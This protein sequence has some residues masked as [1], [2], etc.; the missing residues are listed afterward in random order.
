MRG[1]KYRARK[2]L[3]WGEKE[4]TLMYGKKSFDREEME[5]HETYLAHVA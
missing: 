1:A 3:R 4:N 5:K 2:K